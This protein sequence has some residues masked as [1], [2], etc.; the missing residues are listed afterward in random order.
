M[1]KIV[2]FDVDGTLLSHKSKSVPNSCRKSLELLKK[3][4][5][6]RVIATGRHKLELNDLPVADIE[7]DAYITLNGQLCLD[8]SGN[9]FYENPLYLVL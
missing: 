3:A 7:F 9:I 1:I 5:I 6:D 8:A 2:F 4:K